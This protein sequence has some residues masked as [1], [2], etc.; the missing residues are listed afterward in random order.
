MPL[1]KYYISP[2]PSDPS[3]DDRKLFFHEADT[4]S[5]AIESLIRRGELP[6]NWESMW[7]HFL[8]W[9]DPINGQRGFESLPLSGFS[10]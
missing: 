8:V 6:L 3:P 9:E 4:I 2:L 5:A 7:I 1:Y 10:R